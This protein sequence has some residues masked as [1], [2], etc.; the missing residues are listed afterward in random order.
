MV[1]LHAYDPVRQTRT[2]SFYADSKIQPA[3]PASK[4]REPTSKEI[5]RR[6]QEAKEARVRLTKVYLTVTIIILLLNHN[7]YI[8]P[9]NKNA[10]K[11]V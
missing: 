10:G 8:S 9:S 11:C 5:A 1:L 3:E 6:T 4:F 7:Q 2:Y